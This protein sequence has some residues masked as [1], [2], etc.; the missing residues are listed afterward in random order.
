MTGAKRH[1]FPMSGN[2]FGPGTSEYGRICGFFVASFLT[3]SDVFC[4]GAVT[5]FGKILIAEENAVRFTSELAAV[6]VPILNA[7]IHFFSQIFFFAIGLPAVNK[8]QN[9]VSVYD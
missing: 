9:Y 1:E 7:L 5:S 2:P 6:R 3:I 4:E 8:W